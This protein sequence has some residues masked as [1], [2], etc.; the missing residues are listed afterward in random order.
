MRIHLVHGTWHG[1]WCW[2]AVASQLESESHN[3]V[4]ADLPGLGDNRTPASDVTL[5]RYVDAVCDLLN[6]EEEPVLL[7]G[8]SM[9][10]IVI[11]EAAER[12]PQRVRGLVYVSAYL[13]LDG[14]SMM[15]IVHEDEN[16][17]RLAAFLISD[18]VVCTLQPDKIRETF[19]GQCTVADAEWAASKLVPQAL[20]PFAT[21]IHVTPERFGT[22]P[23]FYIRCL[24]DR[25][26]P[27]SAQD[28]MLAAT[29]CQRVVSVDTDHSPFLSARGQLNEHLLSFCSYASGDA[30]KT[31][32]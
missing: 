20:A 7:V 16:L 24:R 8:H 2:E 15:D 25:A 1:R 18:G 13:L 23:R 10:G 28:I 29:R 31:S 12:M 14:Q 21:P 3:V 27:P 30:V 4:T 19:Y 26:L 5:Q 22:I 11:S 6:A 17:S 9:G 32:A